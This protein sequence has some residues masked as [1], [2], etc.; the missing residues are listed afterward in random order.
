MNARYLTAYHPQLTFNNLYAHTIVEEH[1][2]TEDDSSEDGDSDD[3]DYAT[4]KYFYED[5]CGM[6]RQQNTPSDN[7]Y[8][9]NPADFA[10]PAQ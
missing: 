6:E 3:P 1:C 8:Y 9:E 2:S 4:T 10:K 5:V 7:P